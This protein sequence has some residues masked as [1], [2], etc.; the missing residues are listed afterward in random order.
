MISDKTL[1]VCLDLLS[2]VRIS[3]ADASA[4]EKW[5]NLNRAYAEISNEL[6]SRREGVDSDVARNGK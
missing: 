2:Q 4:Q 1:L 5:E 6:D 3:V